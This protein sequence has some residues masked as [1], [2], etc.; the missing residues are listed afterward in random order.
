MVVLP[1]LGGAAPDAQARCYHGGMAV[2]PALRGATPGAQVRCYHGGTAVLP[3][4][5]SGA[6]IENFFLLIFCPFSLSDDGAKF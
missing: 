5:R 2:L 3:A 1:A 4:H 6:T